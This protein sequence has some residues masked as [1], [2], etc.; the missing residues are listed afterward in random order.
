MPAYAAAFRRLR[1]TP[2]L[3][4]T[5][6]SIFFRNLASKSIIFSP[7]VNILLGENGQGKTNM[8][9]AIYLFKFGRSFRTR[10]DFDMIRFGEKFCRVEVECRFGNREREKYALVVEGGGLKQAWVSGKSVTRLSELVGRYPAV[11]FGPQDLQLVQGAPGERRRFFDMTGSMTDWG[12]FELLKEY[13]RILQQRNAVLKRKGKPAERTVW[14]EGLI[15]TG[16]AL[17]RKRIEIVAVIGEYIKQNTRI[18]S[19]PFEYSLAYENTIMIPGREDG[20]LESMFAM[21]LAVLED[22]EIRRGVTLAGPHRDDIHFFTGG[23]DLK[24]FG[25]QGQKRLLAV[26]LKVAE[27]NHLEGELKEPCVLL[28]DDAFSEF[29]SSIGARLMELLADGRQVFITSPVAL[30]WENPRQNRTFS[31]A[32]GEINEKP[33]ITQ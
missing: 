1:Q 29:D 32:G 14:D 20:D 30:E 13:R 6:S 8:L 11:L 17:A 19:L 31:V 26:L 23:N 9:E 25:S 15:R 22:E 24:K 28:L 2:V 27:L 10:R 7:G 18:H 4:E 21:K 5:L 33:I 12:Y 3:I 16:C